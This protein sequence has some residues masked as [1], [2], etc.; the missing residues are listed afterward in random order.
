MANFLK[1]K[2]FLTLVLILLALAAKSSKSTPSPS[3]T[4]RV[5]GIYWIENPLFPP[6]SID[7][8]LFTHI[9]YAFVSPN[10]FTYKLEEEEEDSTTV[11]TS[12]TTFTNT[13]KTKTPPIP[14]LL[15]IGGATSNSTLFA[16]I[17]SDPTARATFIN[18]TIQVARTFG[19][20]GIDFDW[21]FP[22]TTKE[23]NDLGEL[24][25]QW[26]RAISDEATSTSRP[27]L[28]L[29]AAVYF[30]V[31]FFLSGERRMY[32]VDSIN[33]NLDWV[34]VMSYDLLG[35]GSNVTG[36]PSGMF[37]SKSN[38]S[39]VSGLF[40]WIRGGVA[41][42]K[43]VMG[44]PLYGKSWKLQDPNVHGIGAPN[45]GPG[46]GVD[47]GM[48]YFQVVD[49]NKQMG[50]K[51]V[52]DKETGSVYSYS[53]STWIGYDD[54][55]TVSVKVGFAQALKLGGYFFWAAGYDTS[56]WKVSTQASKA[57]RPE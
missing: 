50:A 10:K 32:P 21:E 7:T 29:T 33:K 28:L 35:S 26:R 37:D 46:P 25:F 31:N 20:D 4:T 27:P 45:V 52:Y 15:S 38:V 56:D 53:G 6:S 9:F 24:L 13:F 14:T 47:G 36:A 18:S 3:S 5:K 12:L 55:F 48:A 16:F 54:P 57:W 51:V 49:F 30:A 2:Q 22:T 41:P 42:E 8:S 1:L 23:M 19:F 43:I 39:V 17:A 40:S 34:N 44:M 11:A